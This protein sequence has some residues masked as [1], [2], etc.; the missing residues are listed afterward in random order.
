ML[1]CVHLRRETPWFL[2]DCAKQE[3]KRLSEKRLLTV[4]TH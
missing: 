4:D 2:H 1:F 3:K